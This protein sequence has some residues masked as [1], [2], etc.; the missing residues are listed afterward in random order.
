[1]VRVY[2]SSTC[3]FEAGASWVQDQCGKW[4]KT[5]LQNSKSSIK[6]Q[7]NPQNDVKMLI[8]KIHDLPVCAG[9]CCYQLSFACNTRENLSGR[10]SSGNLLSTF[11]TWSYYVAKLSCHSWSSCL[12][13]LRV[14]LKGSVIFLWRCLFCYM[15]RLKLLG[16][17]WHFQGF[18]R[19]G[20][21]YIRLSFKLLG[22]IFALGCSLFFI[23][24]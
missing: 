5:V 10:H 15:Q 2:N 21:F 22:G 14:R 6:T 1:M 11:E 19:R 24:I 8:C 12:S 3:Q 20:W 7:Q 9:E 17:L 18:T 4:C 13:L 16:A 23:L